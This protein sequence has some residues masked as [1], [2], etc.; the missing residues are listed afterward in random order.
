M[1]QEVKLAFATIEAARQAIQLAGGRLVVSRRLIDDQL[2]DRPTNPLQSARCTLRIRRDGPRGILAFKGPPLQGTVKIRE[3][4]ETEVS[5]VVA[6][7]A[8]VAA[9]GFSPFFRAQKWREEYGLHAAGE[10]ATIA[11]DDTP[12]GVF[13]EIEADADIIGRVTMAMGRSPAE[14]TLESYQRLFT[15]WATARGLPTSAMRF[16]APEPTP[17]KH[18]T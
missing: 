3:E 9:L 4:I 14:W 5:S 2:Y 17:V 15:A 18:E 6:L 13:V 12:M 10:V 16:D 1:E 8:I 11:L 7:E